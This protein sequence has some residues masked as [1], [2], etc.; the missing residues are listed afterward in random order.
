MWSAADKRSQQQ[1]RRRLRQ[2]T[3][4]RPRTKMSLASSLEDL[5]SW[6]FFTVVCSILRHLQPVPSRNHPSSP[7]HASCTHLSFGNCLK[8]NYTKR[9]SGWGHGS[10]FY[11]YGKTRPTNGGG[12][13]D[14]RS[15][16]FC[17]W[18]GCGSRGRRQEFLFF[19]W[20][21]SIHLRRRLLGR[22]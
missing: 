9:A 22:R 11:Q 5:F 14:F 3:P 6:S 13:D 2:P 19:C 18:L 10:L 4:H 17:F 15:R 1:R 8:G 16:H 20:S 12:D 21:F 7:P